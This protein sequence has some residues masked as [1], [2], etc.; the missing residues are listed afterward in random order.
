MA[1]DAYRSASQAVK[2]ANATLGDAKDLILSLSDIPSE[3]NGIATTLVTRKGNIQYAKVPELDGVDLD[4]YRAKNSQY[5]RI[6]VSE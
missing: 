3:G 4:E 2:L 5:W 6:T 1:T